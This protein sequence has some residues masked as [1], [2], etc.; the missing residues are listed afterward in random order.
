MQ[1]YLFK[2]GRKFHNTFM[3]ELKGIKEIIR[4]LLAYCGDH[5]LYEVQREKLQKEMRY[6]ETALCNAIENNEFDYSEVTT[7]ASSSPDYVSLTGDKA[8]IDA[9]SIWIERNRENFNTRE[10]ELYV[11]EAKRMYSSLFI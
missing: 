7:I 10:I 3:E 8:L 6:H 1:Y 2:E 9:L 5:Y 4:N 11:Q